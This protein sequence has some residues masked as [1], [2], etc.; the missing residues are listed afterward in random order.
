MADKTPTQQPAEQEDLAAVIRK[1][2]EGF[3]ELKKSGLTRNAIVVLLK[4]ATGVPKKQINQVLDGLADL[5]K[6]YT[7]R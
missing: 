2:S 1:V 5:A 4:D 3:E 6:T 7:T